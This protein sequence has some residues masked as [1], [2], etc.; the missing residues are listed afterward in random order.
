MGYVMNFIQHKIKDCNYYDNGDFRIVQQKD[1]QIFNTYKACSWDDDGKPTGYS[2]I[3]KIVLRTENHP[4]RDEHNKIIKD[5]QGNKIMED[6]DV[7]GAKEYTTLEEAKT[8][9]V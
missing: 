6:I 4:V 3:Q 1:K 8:N 2:S 5:E 7:M 9:C